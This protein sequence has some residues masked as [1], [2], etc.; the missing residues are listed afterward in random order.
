[1]ANEK[2]YKNELINKL[3]STEK[4]IYSTGD[5]EKEKEITTP[6]FIYEVN[7]T[8]VYFGVN[9]I[10]NDKTKT[11]TDMPW[12]QIFYPSSAKIKGVIAK[13]N[14]PFTEKIKH[15][16]VYS[17]SDLKGLGIYNFKSN[18]LPT[19]MPDNMATAYKAESMRLLDQNH[20]LRHTHSFTS[21]SRPETNFMRFLPKSPVNVPMFAL[22]SGTSDEK[23]FYYALREILATSVLA[24]TFNDATKIF[25][26]SV[27]RFYDK[28]RPVGPTNYNTFEIRDALGLKDKKEAN[29]TLE[30]LRTVLSNLDTFDYNNASSTTNYRSFVD[31]LKR[32][33]IR[34]NGSLNLLEV[35][36]LAKGYANNEFIDKFMIDLKSAQ[37]RQVP[38][39]MT[40]LESNLMAKSNNDNSNEYHLHRKLNADEVEE[41]INQMQTDYALM[42]LDNIV[43]SIS[44]GIINYAW[45]IANI[46]RPSSELGVVAA[47]IQEINSN[48]EDPNISAEDKAKFEKQL[49]EL[50]AKSKE[51]GTKI[52]TAKADLAK[53]KAPLDLSV[54]DI[55]NMLKK[56]EIPNL[57]FYQKMVQYVEFMVKKA[58]PEIDWKNQND[59]FWKVLADNKKTRP[60]KLDLGV[61]HYSYKLQDKENVKEQYTT[62][63]SPINVYSSSKTHNPRKIFYGYLTDFDNN[64]IPEKAAN[65]VDNKTYVDKNG[66][67]QIS[68]K[69]ATYSIVPYFYL[70]MAP[71]PSIMAQETKF[72]EVVNADNSPE[73]T[74]IINNLI[75]MSASAREQ[76]NNKFNLK[77]ETGLD[78]LFSDS[79]LWVD[80]NN[81]LKA[82]DKITNHAQS[83]QNKVENGKLAAEEEVIKQ[84]NEMNNQD[85]TVNEAKV[86][87]PISETE[88]AGVPPELDNDETPDWMKSLM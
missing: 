18:V 74:N 41:I 51:L 48:L 43:K 33:F 21:F 25:N 79:A 66:Q 20:E 30:E 19:D 7:A 55:K 84:F 4:N 72:N 24:P 56:K 45:L 49:K 6:N 27:V 69:K 29:I 47:N 57:L 58:Y 35:E 88:T 82:P 37:P 28:T 75:S 83:I 32:I 31:E 36:N 38:K 11:E 67:E 61:Y 2:E 65:G 46:D 13:M 64:K 23:E 10:K 86:A 8:N 71:N 70:N 80:K 81:I 44:D 42:Q 78:A 22:P 14:M 73:K 16:Y 68:Y 39:L 54:E 87:E 3:N 77:K 9:K 60:I 76:F 26:N 85:I 40:E 62:K 1:M 50:T 59:N 53:F 5:V 17:N 12:L 52:R 63:I 34:N 15:N